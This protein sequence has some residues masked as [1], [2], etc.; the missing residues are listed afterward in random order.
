VGGVDIVTELIEGSEFDDMVPES[1][2]K[3]NPLDEFKE[4]LS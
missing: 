2:K 1:A 3:L 4:L